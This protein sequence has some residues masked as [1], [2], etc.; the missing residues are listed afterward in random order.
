MLWLRR[1]KRISIGSRLFWRGW[2]TLVHISGRMGHT[3][4]TICARNLGQWMPYNFAA[5]SWSFHTKKLCG[6][7]SLR[8]AHFWIRKTVTLR[9]ETPLGACRATYVCCY[10]M[11]I[12]NF[13]VIIELF[14]LGAFVLSHA[15]TR[16]M[17][18]RADRG[19]AGGFTI[20]KLLC[21]QIQCSTVKSCF[22]HVRTIKRWTQFQSKVT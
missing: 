22:T 9:F 11:L 15:R 20:I 17:D 1:Y 13:I 10:L 4:P 2:F 8:K 18:E 6:T 19:T 14:S 3:P 16:L 21:I 7:L 12:G 5:D